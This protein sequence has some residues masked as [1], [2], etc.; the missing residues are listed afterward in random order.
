MKTHPK[1]VDPLVRYL[2]LDPVESGVVA[3]AV[4]LLHIVGVVEMDH[5]V[6]V[7]NESYLRDK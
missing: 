5:G 6:I 4:L 2:L 7:R 3:G 1:V